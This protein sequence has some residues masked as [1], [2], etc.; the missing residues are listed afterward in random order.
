M[1]RLALLAATSVAALAFGAPATLAAPSWLPATIV[2]G[3]ATATSRPQVAM[4]PRGDVVAIWQHDEVGGDRVEAAARPAGGAWG[5]P[6]LLSPA[7]IEIFNPTVVIAPSGEATVGWST[8]GA[9]QLAQ[10]ATMSPSGVWSGPLTVSDPTVIAEAPAL[11]VDSTGEVTAAWDQYDGVDFHDV[12]SSHP[13]NGSW[14]TPLQ[15]SPA[16]GS[17]SF[18]LLAVDD[19]GDAVAVWNQQVLQVQAAVRLKGGT[20]SGP[21]GLSASGQEIRD[22][23]VAMDAAGEAVV[24]WDRYNG[25]NEVVQS[26]TMSPNGSWG[27]AEDLS[28]GT[29]GAYEPNVAVDAVGEAIVTWERSS[30]T[31]GIVEGTTRTPGSAWSKPTA[32]TPVDQSS[33]DA[34]IAIS[35]GGLAVLTWQDQ[36]APLVKATPYAATRPKGGTW[37]APVGLAPK[38]RP[39]NYPLA[40]T[41]S[42]GDAVAVWEAYGAGTD[43]IEAAGFDGSGPQLSAVSIPAAGQAGEPLPFSVKATDVWSSLA[44]PSWLFGDGTIAKADAVD[45]GYLNGGNYS[46]SVTVTDADGNSSTATGAVAVAGAAAAGLGL[47]RAGSRAL[48]KK[49]RAAVALRCAGG[50]CAG[51]LKLYAPPPRGSHRRRRRPVL[52]GEG[53]FRIASGGHGVVEVKVRRG[54]LVRL[55][56]APTGHLVTSLRGADIAPGKVILHEAKRRHRRRHR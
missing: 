50:D 55:R 31:E 21:I 22:R 32:L 5:A 16:K 54:V 44:P 25:T 53:S 17:A 10:V 19:H 9:E 14:S 11:A 6:V 38:A 45:H 15:I 42:Y 3:P 41:D 29:Y 52:A 8:D 4:D 36:P 18:P 39:G 24:T 13:V 12:V 46:A 48:V 1:R 47:A 23:D 40:A 28:D 35:A 37:S 51:V 7:G 20:W 27:K 43:E 56:R 49:G 33:G 34:S 30:I 2:S 26:A